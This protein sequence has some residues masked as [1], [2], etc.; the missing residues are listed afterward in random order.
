M[1]LK[2][3][4]LSFNLV[5]VQ[6]FWVQF[7]WMHFR[8][9]TFIL[10]DMTGSLA[11][12][13]DR[14]TPVPH[15]E[16]NFRLGGSPPGDASSWVVRHLWVVVGYQYQHL[17]PQLIARVFFCALSLPPPGLQ[18]QDHEWLMVRTGYSLTET[19]PNGWMYSNGSERTGITQSTAPVFC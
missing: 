15:Y 10:A 13:S 6:F 4:K 9:K 17:S 18:W 19:A 3:Q 12:I 2:I 16:K 5:W 1:T 7:F 11:F 8:I 14:L